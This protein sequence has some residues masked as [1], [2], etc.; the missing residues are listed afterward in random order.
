[1]NKNTVKA[2]VLTFDKYRCFT[3]HMIQRYEDLWPNH[4]FTFYVPFQNTP[5]TD[6]TG[7]VIYVRSNPGIKDTVATLLK[8]L[9]GEEIVY[10]CIDDKYP[11]TLQTEIIEELYDD[12]FKDSMLDASGLL[13]SRRTSKMLSHKRSAS[14]CISV[15]GEPL[16]ERDDYSQI[17]IHQ[18]IKVKALEFLFESLPE[19]I[20]SAKS[21][22]ALKDKICK[23]VDHRLFATKRIYGTFGE[24]TSRGEITRNCLKSMHSHQL[25]VPDW[26]IGQ[27]TNKDILIGVTGMQRIHNLIKRWI[28]IKSPN[29]ESLKMQK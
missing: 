9:D 10:W 2:L 28:P 4:P 7:K 29:A 25:L 20:E 21:M 23:P 14:Y 3:D 17:W 26:C 5:A 15:Q 8:D 18:Y 12:V 16:V 1:M 24:S 22:D 11:I 13:F 27:A 19:N 6:K